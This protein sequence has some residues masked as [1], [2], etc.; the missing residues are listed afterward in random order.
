MLL[1]LGAVMRS[2]S[3]ALMKARLLTL[4]SLSVIAVSSLYLPDHS[5]HS[6]VNSRNQI[7]I[8][9]SLI[10][11]KWPKKNLQQPPNLLGSA[12]QTARW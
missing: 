10:D 1:M 6:V 11:Q 7:G 2:I 8:L 9:S 12:S 3:N 5:N 4:H